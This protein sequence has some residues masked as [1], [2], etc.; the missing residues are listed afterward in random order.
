M[1]ISIS[2]MIITLLI[3]NGCKYDEGTTNCE[4]QFIIH[5][6]DLDSLSTNYLDKYAYNKKLN[7]II[8]Y[9]QNI[10]SLD[11]FSFT[12]N[13][14]IKRIPLDRNFIK[15][16]VGIHF[17][18]EDSIFVSG[19][20]KLIII[21]SSGELTYNRNLVPSNED[22]R[23]GS[24]MH[25]L[26]TNLYYN[27]KRNSCFFLNMHSGRNQQQLSYP[28][29]AEFNLND[30]QCTLHEIT[31]PKDFI[32]EVG[33]YGL[34]NEINFTVDEYFILYNF[35]FSNHVY[36]YSI[37]EQQIVADEEIISSLTPNNV[38]VLYA[39]SG[40]ELHVIENSRFF[41]VFPSETEGEYY[42]ITWKKLSN[43]STD[44]N[45]FLLKPLIV[46]K[47]SFEEGLL[48]E[49]ELENNT[50]RVFTWFMK[51]G[52]LNINASHPNYIHLSDDKM[53]FIEILL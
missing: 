11:F 31:Y 9:N 21:N 5:S 43:Y 23:I 20:N 18:N 3:I 25:T 8:N 15:G 10:H 13:S 38:E 4:A 2:I 17:Y 32:D 47:F 36:K 39:E 41:G 14:I 16:V 22:Q 40:A 46:S 19:V 28:L 24:L 6:V 37:A 45:P 44:T 35:P 51:G 1:K 29:V 30:S 12:N 33:S 42:R 27:K 50:Y 49:I 53:D 26:N 52:K 7:T 34:L 48:C